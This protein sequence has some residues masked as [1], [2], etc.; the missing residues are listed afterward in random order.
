L[1]SPVPSGGGRG[2]EQQILSIGLNW[3]PVPALKFEL[4]FQNVHI[5]RIGTIPAGFGHGTLNNASV[6]QVF[7]TVALRSQ[8]SL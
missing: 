4:Q 1:G 7:D 6:G 5:E 2:G 3:F 8:L